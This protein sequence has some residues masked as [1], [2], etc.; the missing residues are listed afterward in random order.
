MK[1]T[2]WVRACLGGLVYMET[3]LKAHLTSR[4][5]WDAWRWKTRAATC[6]STVEPLDQLDSDAQLRLNILKLYPPNKK[7]NIAIK[8]TERHHHSHLQSNSTS[9]VDQSNLLDAITRC[10]ALPKSHVKRYNCHHPDSI[11][12]GR[13]PPRC[14]K[15]TPPRWNQQKPKCFFSSLKR[16]ENW[17]K[18]KRLEVFSWRYKLISQFFWDDC[19][20]T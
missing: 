6:S 7:N 4:L 20:T 14:I 1:N 2:T 17:D 12:P 11:S 10:H 16:E 19:N 8:S 5:G 3:Q 18:Q 9:I 15:M 13:T